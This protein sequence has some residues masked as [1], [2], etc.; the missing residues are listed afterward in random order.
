M[1]EFL[2]S[3]SEDAAPRAPA[4]APPLPSRSPPN[5]SQLLAELAQAAPHTELALEDEPPQDRESVIVEVLRALVAEPEAAARP[6]G[7]LFQDFPVRCRMAGIR[8]PLLDPPGF[9]PETGRV[10]HGCVRTC[11]SR[12]S[13]CPSKKNTSR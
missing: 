5:T 6:I 3:D 13:P 7:A 9:R 12:W 2:R 1:R 10:G 4:P 11:R 8:R